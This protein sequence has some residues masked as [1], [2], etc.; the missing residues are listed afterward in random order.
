VFMKEHN[1]DGWAATT[2][3]A[4]TTA[5]AGEPKSI[6]TESITDERTRRQGDQTSAP[7]VPNDPGLYNRP[8]SVRDTRTPSGLLSP[9]HWVHQTW[10]VHERKEV[11][12][13]VRYRRVH[14]YKT[15]AGH[16]SRRA[17]QARIPGV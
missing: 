9:D 17:P 12:E 11:A 14:W 15:G 5:Y 6:V 7:L 8:A 2:R 16:L 1:A 4:L 3:G 13:D 10:R